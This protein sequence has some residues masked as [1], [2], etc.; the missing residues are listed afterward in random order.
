[1]PAEV[2]GV[3]LNLCRL[4][5]SER[6]VYDRCPTVFFCAVALAATVIFWPGPMSPDPDVLDP[7]QHQDDTELHRRPPKL[8]T[9]IGALSRVWSAPQP[10][11]QCNDASGGDD[12]VAGRL[13]GA[14]E[15]QDSPQR[16][17][18]TYLRQTQCSFLQS[19]AD[20]PCG[21]RNVGHAKGVSVLLWCPKRCHAVPV[22]T[23]N[24]A[25]SRRNWLWLTTP[26][27]NGSAI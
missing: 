5:A 13:A 1:V 14:E 22:N 3:A 24:T 6:R 4:P 17:A 15:G 25:N 23:P 21:L 9:R 16:S 18:Q 2:T 7:F 19:K 20:Q 26:W 8:A 11:R 27:T 10:A 12:D